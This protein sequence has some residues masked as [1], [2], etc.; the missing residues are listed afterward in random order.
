VDF[1]SDPESARSAINGWVE[2]ETRERVRDLIPVGGIDPDTRLVLANA[3]YFKAAWM[4][5]F[6]EGATR[7]APFY[8]LDGREVLAPTMVTQ[9]PFGYAAGEVYQAVELPYA[10]GE[11]SLV[12]L[13]PDAGRFEEFERALDPERLAECLDQLA[14]EAGAPLPPQV[15]VHLRVHAQPGPG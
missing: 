5:P 10:G 7:D 12:I 14:P 13:L 11:A 3:V 8:L 1:L 4:F 6:S 15:R 9:A 2:E